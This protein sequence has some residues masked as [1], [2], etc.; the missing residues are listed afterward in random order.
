MVALSLYPV[1]ML[2]ILKAFSKILSQIVVNK[3]KIR[4]PT[5]Q[6]VIIWC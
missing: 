4:M 5:L 6:E 3:L 1:V 2:E